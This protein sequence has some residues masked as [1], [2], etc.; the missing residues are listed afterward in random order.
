MEA[1][2]QFDWTGFMETRWDDISEPVG[3]TLTTGGPT[4]FNDHRWDYEAGVRP[5]RIGVGGSRSPSSTA[6]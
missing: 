3:N 1:D 6:T 2:A 5:G 4:R